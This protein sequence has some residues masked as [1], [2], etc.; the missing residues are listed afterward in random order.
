MFK[1]VAI[2]DTHNRHKQIS[3]FKETKYNPID[4][5]DKEQE[6]LGGDIIIHAGDATGRGE[7]GEIEPFIKWYG[8]LDFR[9]RIFIAGNHD[10][11]FERDPAR[12]KKLCEDNGVILLNHESIEIEGIKIFGSPWTPW[13]YNW[14]FN[15]ARNP[16]E[17]LAYSKQTKLIPLMK[18]LWNDI[19][20]DTNI[21]VTHGPP[22]EIL[23]ELQFVDGTPKG[24]FVGCV[25]LANKIKELKDLDLHI[26]GHIHCQHGQ[27][28]IDG[29]SYYNVSICDEMYSPSMPVT[30]IDYEKV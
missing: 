9:Y 28:H 6:P 12:Y 7:S 23:D 5:E 16:N 21:L 19:P 13:F 29:V 22:Y 15:G 24:Q 26:F 4:G 30:V 20:L 10:F 2:S 17:Q 18:D 27:K 14:A 1:I 3:V 8:Q 25:D 11:G